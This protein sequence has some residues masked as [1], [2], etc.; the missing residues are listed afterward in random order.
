MRAILLGIFNTINVSRYY[1]QNL[2]RCLE[3]ELTLETVLY[4]QNYNLQSELMHTS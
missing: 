1:I 3:Y 4:F 2:Q